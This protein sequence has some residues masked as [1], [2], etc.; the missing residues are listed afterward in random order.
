MTPNTHRSNFL[1][2]ILCVIT[3]TTWNYR[4]YKNILP[5]ECLLYYLRYPFSG[6]ELHAR[7][8]QWVMDPNMNHNHFS[9]WHFVCTYAHNSKT[10]G[11]IWTFYISNDCSSIRDVELD[12]R[13]G[14][15]VMTPN[16][17][18]SLFPTRHLCVLTHITWKLDMHVWTF[19]ILNDCSTIKDISDVV[20]SCMSDSTGKLQPQTCIGCSLMQHCVYTASPYTIRFLVC[21]YT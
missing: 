6:L 1:Y 12:E 2:A 19:C 14:W 4:L 18:C 16:T 13:Y 9:I 20:Q 21:N 8:E 11:R 15:Q 10:T 17:H 5:I 3:W 7:C